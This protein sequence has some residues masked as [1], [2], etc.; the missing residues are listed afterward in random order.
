MFMWL[1][2]SEKNTCFVFQRTEL[3]K[4]EYSYS[5]LNELIIYIWHCNVSRIDLNWIY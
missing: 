5:E 1:F 2:I 3:D 4:G